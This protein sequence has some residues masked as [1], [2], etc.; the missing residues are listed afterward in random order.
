LTNS[1]SAHGNA[2]RIAAGAGNVVASRY[3]ASLIDV[4]MPAGAL[5]AVQNDIISLE[6][7]LNQSHDLKAF[8][9]SPVYGAD[10]QLAAIR[11]IA[12]KC[13]FHQI[14]I[15]FLCVLAENRRLKELEMIIGAFHREIAKRMGQMDAFVK[16]AHPLTAQQEENLARML[17]EKT[18][19]TVRLYVEID[20]E[21][22][23]GMV[24]TIGS[25]MIDD[26]LKSK[27]ARLKQTMVTNS[28]SNQNASLKE[29]G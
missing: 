20:Q 3:A 19:K 29:V 11:D 10:R 18:G 6:S 26:S 21:L 8:V 1:S 24:V 12:Q 13:R 7:T 4:A 22:L 27:L 28:N 14:T 16:T 15:N 9:E 5:E 2:S 23:G 25:Q 17:A